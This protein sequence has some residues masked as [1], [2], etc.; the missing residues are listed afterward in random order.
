M[1]DGRS[2]RGKSG[3]AAPVGP[4]ASALARLRGIEPPACPS[5]RD[6]FFARLLADFD[7]AWEAASIENLGEPAS[8]WLLGLRSGAEHAAER[9]LYPARGA[10]RY[11]RFCAAALHVEVDAAAPESQVDCA[12]AWAAEAARGGMA[13]AAAKSL[14]CAPTFFRYHDLMAVPLSVVHAC[15]VTAA[16]DGNPAAAVR[17]MPFRARLAAARCS[18]TYLRFVVGAALS[19]DGG[20]DAMED[21]HLSALEEV[22]RALL[23][24]RL[25]VPV[26]VAVACGRNFYGAAHEGLR[27]YQAARLGRIVAGIDGRGDVS[28]LLDLRGSGSQRR[29]RLAL[30][31]DGESLAACMLQ[32]PLDESPGQMH[33]RIAAWLRGRGIASI[34]AL[35]P[36]GACDVPCEPILAIPV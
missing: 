5:A 30:R 34:V 28:A 3:A 32:M 27:R 15:L 29:V 17:G 16:A 13:P 19:E 14:T 35:T 7:A 12:L 21:L 4:P 22:V 20:E 9:C 33:A 31:R 36:G 24:V 26:R 10:R 23:G 8:T 2:A 1:A 11:V 18:P 6:E 25:R